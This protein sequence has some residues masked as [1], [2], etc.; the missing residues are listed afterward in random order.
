[1]SFLDSLIRKVDEIFQGIERW[2]PNVLKLCIDDS[3]RIYLLL[4]VA[5]FRSSL[6]RSSHGIEK[7]RATR[8][9]YEDLRLK[10]LSNSHVYGN[11]PGNKLDGS[12]Q[13]QGCRWHL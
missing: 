13:Q 9:A 3:R 5:F 10:W 4:P 11:K 1:M 6:N 2:S 12:N 8:Y 7:T